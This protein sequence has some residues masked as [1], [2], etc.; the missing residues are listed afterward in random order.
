MI[1]QYLAIDRPDLVNKL[2]LCVTLSRNNETV[3]T[4]VNNWI[5]MAEKGDMKAFVKDMAEKMYSD[6]YV[7]RY[8][9]F[10]PILTI[11]Q[12]PKD[13]K[14]FIT[15]AK[16]CLTCEAYDE[17]DKINCP[18]FVLGGKKDKVVTGEASEEIADKLN[19]GIYM[20]ENLGHSAYEE[21]KDFNSRI[22]EFLMK[23][24]ID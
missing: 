13:V 16:A 5:E 9:L 12:K 4:V 20:Y 15:L 11:M 17:L 2:V 6:E 8:K 19:C 7:R 3:E 1:S 21:A 18:V 10:M 14:R 22:Y 23:E 24:R